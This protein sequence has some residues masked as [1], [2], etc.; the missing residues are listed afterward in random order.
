MIVTKVRIHGVAAGNPFLLAFASSTLDDMFVIHDLK[1][2]QGKERIFVAMPDRKIVEGC[3]DCGC[4][5]FLEAHVCHHCRRVLIV[6]PP[7][8]EVHARIKVHTDIVH[9]LT[10][11][12]RALIENPVLDA[13]RKASDCIKQTGCL[14]PYEFVP[15]PQPQHSR[16]DEVTQ[17]R[18]SSNGMITFRPSTTVEHRPFGDGIL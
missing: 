6:D 14:G 2:I 3:L 5:N 9:P 13:F 17:R 15:D 4:L 8:P 11:D 12:C 18:P 16:S 1:V 7:D 10:S